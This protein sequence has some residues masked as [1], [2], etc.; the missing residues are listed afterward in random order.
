MKED[1]RY[2]GFISYRHCDL[3]KFVAE[4]L[5]TLI[6]TYKMPKA[7]VEKYNIT[8]N[9]VRRIFRDQ[10]ELPLSG[11][12]N[13]SIFKALKES[14]FLIV[15]CSPRLKESMWCRKEIQNFIKLHGR[16]N[17]LCVLIEGEPNESFPE[18]LMYYEEKTKTKTG[19]EKIKKISCEPL[20][21]DVRGKNKKEIYKNLK[22]ELIRV[23]APMYNLNYDDIKR[24]HEEREL[25][26]KVKLF[27]IITI[28]SIIFALYSSFLF[29][30]IYISS[31]K[32]KYD[33]A[34]SLADLSKDKLSKDD[35]KGA[36]LSAYQSITKY[37]NNKMPVTTKGIYELTESLGI[38]YTSNNYYPISKLNTKGLIDSIKVDLDKKYLLSYDNSK[39]LILWNLENESKVTTIVDFDLSI[40]K[41]K[42]TFIGNDKFAYQNNS[43]N[44]SILNLNGE[45]INEI[46]FEYVISEL[47]SSINGKYI[48]I[49]SNDKIYVYDTDKYELICSYKSS[50][51]SHIYFDE[52]EENIVVVMGVK[53]K[54]TIISNNI[55]TYNISKK[56]EI[57][58]II[59]PSNNVVKTI[60]KGN[61]LIVLLN[62]K[63][64]LTSNMIVLSYNY[65]NGKINY[66]KEYKEELPLD[67]SMKYNNKKT[68]L[69]SSFGTSYLLDFNSGRELARFSIG[70]KVVNSYSVDDSDSYLLFTSSGETHIINSVI[71]GMNIV[72]NDVVFE[73]LYNFNLSN[74]VQYLYSPKGILAYTSTDNRIVIYGKLYNE[75][76]KEVEYEE[77]EFYT[78]NSKDK[79]SIVKEYN[80]EKKN[81][82][83]GMVY[84]DDKTLLFVNYSDNTLEIYNSDKKLLNSVEGVK[85]IEAY[86]GK[87]DRNEHIIR[88]Y[89]N[90]YIL[91]KDFELIAYVPRL[92]DYS[93]D[94]LILKQDTKFYSV[95]IYNEKDLINKAKNILN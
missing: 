15:I 85:N 84:S 93:N 11:S 67:M 94:K 74:Y 59:V 77:R 61:N 43:K 57:S 39:E 76:I 29:L 51:V 20:A 80:F 78:I 58:N 12:L 7:V 60:F 45:K 6:E 56:R 81:L 47:I 46:K 90:G 70:D 23:I 40:N 48:G 72:E 49:L 8:D 38:Y 63:D 87:T 14:K 18:E 73:G 27:R 83:T 3:D 50:N 53:Q 28:A 32:L 75:D 1:L 91:N 41:N 64:D 2:N 24:R 88:S 33:Q 95:K 17:I 44:V 69:V 42:Y 66:K 10:E 21:M 5:H 4:N 19:K 25:K 89:N 9:D 16:D 34:I 52:T 35:R 22:K 68:L 13:D 71:S 36:I 82:I 79:E 37:N 26:R 31:N 30:K 55:V 86:V 62:K 65:K 92:Y 54:Q